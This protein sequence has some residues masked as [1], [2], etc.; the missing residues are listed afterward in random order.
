MGPPHGDQAFARKILALIVAAGANGM[1]RQELVAVT[2]EPLERIEET[3]DWLRA[4]GLLQPVRRE[5]MH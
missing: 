5:S 3:L 4:V 2:G 1:E